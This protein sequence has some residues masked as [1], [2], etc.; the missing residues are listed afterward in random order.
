M[1]DGLALPSAVNKYVT[2]AD[3]RLG[4]T[5]LATQT[6]DTTTTSGTDVLIAGMQITLGAGDDGDYLIEFSSSVENTNN[7]NTQEVVI[8]AGAT[9]TIVLAS[10]RRIENGAGQAAPVHCL[11]RVN[12]LVATDTIEVRWRTSGNTATAHERVLIAQRIG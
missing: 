11:A 10:E 8:Y 1:T 6:G 5:L 2:D 9:P 7:G 12:G 3:K 4:P